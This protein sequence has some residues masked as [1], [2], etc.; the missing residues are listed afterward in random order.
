M[1]DVEGFA[2][3]LE[4]E[5]GVGVAGVD[6]GDVRRPVA[7]PGLKGLHPHLGVGVGAG[8][9]QDVPE[10]G[11]PPAGRSAPSFDAGDGEDRL[12]LGKRAQ[13]AQ[14]QAEWSLDLPRHL[15]VVG[16]VPGGVG[17]PAAPRSC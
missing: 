3:Q 14:G 9:L 6:M 10:A 12:V 2:V 17:T 7:A 11:A 16:R 5:E 8:S 13:V 15:E 4:G 1:V